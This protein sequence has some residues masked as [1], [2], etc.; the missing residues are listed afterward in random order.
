MSNLTSVLT[1]HERWMAISYT[2]DSS[3]FELQFSFV[4]FHLLALK[5]LVVWMHNEN[6]KSFSI[7]IHVIRFNSPNAI[8]SDCNLLKVYDGHISW[9]LW[10]YG[11]VSSLK[12]ASPSGAGGL[13]FWLGSFVHFQ[14]DVAG[15]HSCLSSLHLSFSLRDLYRLLEKLVWWP[16]LVTL[17]RTLICPIVFLQ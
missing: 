17:F 1:S 11:V 15:T 12:E 2:N 8:Q 13:V 10:G 5:I 4:L 9:C 3:Y 6:V 14:I 7:F 16:W